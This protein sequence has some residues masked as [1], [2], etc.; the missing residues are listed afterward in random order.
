MDEA[1]QGAG[2]GLQGHKAD[3][4]FLDLDLGIGNDAFRAVGNDRAR[5]DFKACAVICQ[6]Q[7]VHARALNPGDAQPV[8]FP[9]AVARHRHAVHDHLVK[10]REIGI[11]L[12][13]FHQD[14]AQRIGQRNVFRGRLSSRRHHDLRRAFHRNQFGVRPGKIV[15]HSRSRKENVV[16]AI[17]EHRKNRSITLHQEERMRQRYDRSG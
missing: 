3:V 5:H 8:A 11:R 6:V 14:T 2:N 4:S 17:L 15:C 16:H 1:I 12:D 7:A 13:A 9:R 10:S